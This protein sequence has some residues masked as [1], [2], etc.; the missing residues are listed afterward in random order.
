MKFF[1][2]NAL[3]YLNFGGEPQ[4]RYLLTGKSKDKQEKLIFKGS[5]RNGNA[6][7]AGDLPYIY[8]L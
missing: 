1:R 6:P 8:F 3:T 2:R 5:S 7:V 4:D